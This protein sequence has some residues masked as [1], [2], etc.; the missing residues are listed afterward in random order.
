MKTIVLAGLKD[1]TNL[2]DPVIFECTRYLLDRILSDDGEP[3]TILPCDLYA[4]GWLEWLL[5]LPVRIVSRVARGF[6]LPVDIFDRWQTRLSTFRHYKRLAKKADAIVVAGGGLIKF[7]Y[8]EFDYLLGGLIKAADQR[9][10]PVMFNS[11]GVEGFDAADKRCLR[12]LKALNSPCVRM[13]TTRDDITTLRNNYIKRPGIICEPAADPA[14]WVEDAFQICQN[15]NSGVVGIGVIRPGIFKDNGILYTQ[16]QL[17][18][19]FSGMIDR[20]RAQ[21]KKWVLFT[22]GLQ[23]DTAFAVELCRHIGCDPAECLRIP[24]TARELVT[25]ISGFA[26]VIACRLHAT[27]IAYALGISAVG[28]VW[29]AKM[30][31]FGENIG[32][33]DRFI[34]IDKAAP[35]LVT[36][37][38][39]Q[40]MDQPGNR[41][42]LLQYRDT[43]R[44]YLEVFLRNLPVQN[45]EM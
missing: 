28:L 30:H 14:L 35:A 7:R 8:Q 26:G 21:N 19:L 20:L 2:G 33:P 11:V 3:Y 23:A 45:G 40:A 9:K 22:N 5:C 15:K 1:D 39:I 32:C 13:V 10:I 12:L 43:T 18:T 27:I 16:E 37:K 24:A 31:F 36:Q 29:N 41:S 6:H 44:H 42:N 34:D 38:L 25:L 4:S 17:L